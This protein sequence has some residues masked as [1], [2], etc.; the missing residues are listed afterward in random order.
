MIEGI[1]QMINSK[2]EYMESASI[3]LEDVTG[4][5]FD[6]LIV[7]GEEGN[8]DFGDTDNGEDIG[9]VGMED[10]SEEDPENVKED[11]GDENDNENNG[12]LF[13]EPIDDDE[14]S[15]GPNLGTD[16]NGF[17]NDPIDPDQSE[18]PLPLPDDGLPNPVGAQT[19]MDIEP[20]DDLLSM[21]IDLRSN[22]A[23]D[24]LPIPPKNAIEA[25]PGSE[26]EIPTHNVDSGF[27]GDPVEDG[28]INEPAGAPEGNVPGEDPL[29]ES[30]ALVVDAAGIRG[31]HL[32]DMPYIIYS[33]HCKK[34]GKSAVSKK[35]FNTSDKFNDLKQAVYASISKFIRDEKLKAIK[36]STITIKQ[37]ERLIQESTFDPNKFRGWKIDD[38]AY[39]LYTMNCNN[40]KD[41]KS[42]MADTKLS[43]LWIS[44]VFGRIIQ[45][46]NKKLLGSLDKLDRALG[47]SGGY[48]SI[49]TNFLNNTRQ[50]YETISLGDDNSSDDATAS[51][52]DAAQQNS[53]DAAPDAELADEPV[54]DGSGENEVTTAVRDKVAEADTTDDMSIGSDESMN[55]D[56]MALI[57]KKAN[58]SQRSLDDLKQE[59][60]NTL[61]NR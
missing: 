40:P 49:L 7:L 2:R 60:F 46:D 55:G 58:A 57:W 26:D 37:Y 24:I 10:G 47:E 56:A 43:G 30:A 34:K 45:A 39:E 32:E 17:M 15:A 5:N 42:F 4:N 23:N 18:E 48:N 19:G 53:K 12:S 14:Q 61:K 31:Y 33:S 59:I 21:N 54:E 36:E 16:T 35:E 22:T 11:D 50:Y 25:I 51:D 20:E 38:I 27:A 28:S 52:D 3:L 8:E 29:G 13:D 6:D 1:K 9:E 41:K 44:K